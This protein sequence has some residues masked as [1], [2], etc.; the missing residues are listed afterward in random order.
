MNLNEGVVSKSILKKAGQEIQTACKKKAPIT[1][2]SVV[3]TPSGNLQ[4]LTGCR[5]ICHGVLPEWYHR[6]GLSLKVS[7]LYQY[8]TQ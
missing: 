8:K 6:T 2:G 3:V 4:Q 1:V 5:Y 7:W